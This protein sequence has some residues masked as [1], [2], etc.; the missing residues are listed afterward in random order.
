MKSISLTFG[1]PAKNPINLFFLSNPP[2]MDKEI[3]KER[4]KKQNPIIPMTHDTP[5]Q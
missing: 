4:L 3:D 2:T 1:I 5:L